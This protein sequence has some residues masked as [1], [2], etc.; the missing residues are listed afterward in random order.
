MKF[1]P[2]SDNEEGG[3]VV[4]R[5]RN[6][7]LKFTLGMDNGN[8]TLKLDRSAGPETHD[9]LITSIAL[10]KSP[11]F[12]KIHVSGPWFSFMYSNDGK[13]WNS[14]KE[15]VDGRMLGLAGAGRFTGT[16]IGMYAS[17]N[18]NPSDNFIDFDWFEYKPS[19]R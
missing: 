18:G 12:L 11:A 1:T 6:H 4:I 2:A 3:L 19:E 17:S 14:L 15:K 13:T 9:L 10:D 16:M 8:V 7:Y 5:D